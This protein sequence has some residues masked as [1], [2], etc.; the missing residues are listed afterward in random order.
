MLSP[1]LSYCPNDSRALSIFEELRRKPNI[2]E[3]EQK[4][5]LSCT[6]VS[7]PRFPAKDYDGKQSLLGEASSRSQQR[8]WC[9]GALERGPVSLRVIIPWKS[10]QEE[11]QLTSMLSVDEKF[12]WP[13]AGETGFEFNLEKT[14][15]EVRLLT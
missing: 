3:L 12:L 15:T 1:V 11:K 10:R 5:V 6:M 7:C 14:S 4:I 13:R 8:A 9:L 2:I